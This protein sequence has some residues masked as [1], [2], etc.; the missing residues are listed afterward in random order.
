ME[1]LKI[2][3]ASMCITTYFI[4][5]KTNFKKLLSIIYMYIMAKVHNINY[6]ASP[7]I[8][9]N[10]MSLQRVFLREPCTS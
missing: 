7:R 3:F 8:K 10:I 9:P 4:T 2:Y 5:C 6:N 1:F